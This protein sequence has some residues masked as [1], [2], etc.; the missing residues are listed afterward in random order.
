MNTATAIRRI[1]HHKG[2]SQTELAARCGWGPTYVNGM[3][4]GRDHAGPGV[5][6]KVGEATGVPP[7]VFFLLGAEEGDAGALGAEAARAL[8]EDLLARL[9]ESGPAP[10]QRDP[11]VRAHELAADLAE[12]RLRLADLERQAASLLAAMGAV[13]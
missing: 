1:L 5:M 11:R 4:C 3:A 8:G 7:V 13:E 10:V 12:V 9:V 2:W 6:A